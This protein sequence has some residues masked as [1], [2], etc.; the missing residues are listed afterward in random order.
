MQS[1]N[2]L[3]KWLAY[4][5]YDPDRKSFVIGSLSYEYHKCNETIS[6]F[7]P[8]NPSA[9]ISVLY[10]RHKFKKILEQTRLNALEIISN[11]TEIHPDIEMWQTLNSPAVDQMK[12]TVLDDFNDLLTKAIPTG[13]IGQRD[14]DA[15]RNALIGSI[16]AVVEAL[17]KCNVDLYLRGGPIGNVTNFSTH[18]HVFDQLAQCLLAL[19]NSP[20]GIYLCYI[21]NYGAVYGFFGFFIK[22]NGT[23]LSI[24]E[25]LD[26]AYPGGHKS[27]RNNRYAEQKQ[28]DLFPYNFIFSFDES[29]YDYKGYS[30]SH[31]INEEQ[32]A[33]FKLQPSAYLPLVIA[34]VLL[35]NR[36]NGYDPTGIGLQYIDSLLPVN[37]ALPT[38]GIQELIVPGD[39]A[40]V[41][42]NSALD[43]SFSQED[44]ISGS[45]VELLGRPAVNCNDE[46]HF[47]FYDKPS[48][49]IFIEKYA[50]DF[51]LDCSSLFESNR[52]LKC[53]TANQLATTT[54]TP[55]AEFVGT[56]ERMM[57]IAY[58]NARNQLAEH[59]RNKMH[60]AYINSGGV[61]A[62]KSWWATALPSIKSKLIQLCVERYQ[63]EDFKT[64]VGEG[65]FSIMM[66]LNCKERP[67]RVYSASY[68]LNTW[69]YTR[70]GYED[71]SHPLCCITGTKSSHYF[72]VYVDTYEQMV[73]LFGKENVPD[74]LTGYRRHGHRIYG[75]PI[76]SITDPMTGLGTPFEDNEYR[77]NRRLWSKS[78][79][80][81]YIWNHR[82][83]FD[84][85]G[86]MYQSWKPKDYV[87]ENAPEYASTTDFCFV[88]AFSKRGLKKALEGG[89]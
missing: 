19:E 21:K 29:G 1:I 2:I 31:V 8:Y 7:S 63:N 76:L 18:I 65:K 38:P 26:E 85:P 5:D 72:T 15:E 47:G 46:R 77:I 59:I 51:H 25:R 20:D 53:L 73:S 4:S 54:L 37:L 78:H 43:L 75:N 82:Q 64:P 24:N 35:R 84:D 52:H 34:M 88:I 30:T 42:A 50:Q 69:G 23:I 32:L 45:L 60:A 13:M 66:D 55:D 62:V 87:P 80:E 6:K 71:H 9:E 36:Y 41:K 57:Q 67:C 56:A 14:I 83:E 11:P 86:K 44:V 40:L 81:D 33:F 22:S 70:S 39:S 74:I 58:M 89:A 27:H 48:E 10:A 61:N 68:P 16:E 28:Y 12:K 79:W 49:Q 3:K 17:Y